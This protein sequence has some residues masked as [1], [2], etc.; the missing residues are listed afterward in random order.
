MTKKKGDIH[1]G[2]DASMSVFSLKLVASR[3]AAS[4]EIEVFWAQ[5]ARICLLEQSQ[6]SCIHMMSSISSV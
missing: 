2:R 3:L 5:E 4:V 1:K 6:C